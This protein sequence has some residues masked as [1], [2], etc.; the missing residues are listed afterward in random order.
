MKGLDTLYQIVLLKNSISKEEIK[1]NYHNISL[2]TQIDAPGVKEFC[3]TINR[4]FKFCLMMLQESIEEFF[5]DEEVEKNLNNK[6][7]PF[8]FFYER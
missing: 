8:K 6:N 4:A 5:L 2:L 1:K 3:K 7:W